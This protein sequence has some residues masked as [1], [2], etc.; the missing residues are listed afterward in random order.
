MA[1]ASPVPVLLFFHLVLLL[2][3]IISK[4][5][6]GDCTEPPCQGKQRWPELVGKDENTAY[7]NIK[8]DN[9]QVT[10]VEYLI[11][12]VVAGHAIEK[13]N[14]RGEAGG[15]S[16]DNFCCNRVVVV[17]GRLPSGEEGVVKEPQVG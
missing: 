9:P 15:E 13:R 8:R 17:L 10:D 12:D 5:A 7:N 1:K 2:P 6:A 14:V 16:E 3:S 4:P 11:S